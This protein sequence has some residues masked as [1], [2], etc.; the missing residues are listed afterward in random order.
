MS[1][2]PEEERAHG[3]ITMK[4][5]YKYFTTERGHL[6]TLLMVVTFI[7]AEVRKHTC[8]LV[9]CTWITRVLVTLCT[10]C[11]KGYVIDRVSVYIHVYTLMKKY[12][13][14]FP[15]VIK[16]H[17]CDCRLP[18]NSRQSTTPA[19]MK[20][21]RLDSA[22]R[23][24]MLKT[25]MQYCCTCSTYSN[26]SA[27]RVYVHVLWNSFCLFSLFYRGLL[28]VMTGGCQ[29]GRHKHTHTH[30]RTHTHTH[31]HV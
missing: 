31:V 27:H 18:D 11:V 30:A 15:F 4:T 13:C 9:L 23:C 3:R 19:S 10:V 14:C 22:L 6:F 26:V 16:C 12:L 20:P 17:K 29:T 24:R 28:C 25:T 5:Y 8:S 2:L 1:Q 21:L 7:L